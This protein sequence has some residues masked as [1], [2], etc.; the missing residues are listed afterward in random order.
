[1][2]TPNLRP[3]PLDQTRQRIVEQLCDHYAVENLTDEALDERLRKAYAATSLAELTALVAD[4]PVAPA[5][6]AAPGQSV[7][8]APT[9]EIAERQVLVAV[10][11]GTER[12]G[13]W[14]P[15]RELNVVAVMGGAELDFRQARFGPGVTVVNCFALMGGVQITVPP[16]V[17][18]EMNGMA[19]MGGFVQKGM[20]DAAP[21]PPGAPVLRIG[22]FALMGGVEVDM[23]HAGES[24]GDARRRER[25]HRAELR[26]LRRGR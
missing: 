6:A 26:R 3:V 13:V 2:D 21:P 12:H 15:P 5:E 10:M 8:V 19:I 24:A 14:T 9:G 20:K 18:V 17:Q 22:G 4:L 1:M 25:L 16:G 7:A 11:S 23:R